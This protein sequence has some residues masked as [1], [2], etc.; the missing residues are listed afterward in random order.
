[1]GDLYHYIR[2]KVSYIEKRQKKKRL[3]YGDDYFYKNDNNQDTLI[4]LTLSLS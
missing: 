3:D 2:T 1:M 4:I